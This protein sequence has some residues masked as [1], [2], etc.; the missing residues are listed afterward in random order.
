MLVHRP[1]DKNAPLHSG[2]SDIMDKNHSKTPDNSP[3][4]YLLYSLV[5]GV[6]AAISYTFILWLEF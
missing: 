5:L 3:I 2:V 6:F 4:D 1:T